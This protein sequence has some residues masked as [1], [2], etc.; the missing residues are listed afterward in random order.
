MRN[1]DIAQNDL[2]MYTCVH[3]ILQGLAYFQFVHRLSY[4]IMDLPFYIIERNM[5]S[6]SFINY[7]LIP[8]GDLI[9]ENFISKIAI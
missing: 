8:S 2:H 5:Y 6:H 1:K 9:F 3:D 7:S 4:I